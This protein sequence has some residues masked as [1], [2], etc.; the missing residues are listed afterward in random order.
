MC[1]WPPMPIATQAAGVRCICLIIIRLDRGVL[2]MKETNHRAPLSKV[3]LPGWGVLDLSPLSSLSF[4][5]SN[6]RPTATSTPSHTHRVLL[7]LKSCLHRAYSPTVNA[8]AQPPLLLATPLIH[9]Q[10]QNCRNTPH[11][12]ILKDFRLSPLFF[13][14]LT[15]SQAP[16]TNHQLAA[17]LT[18]L[19]P[20]T[21]P[22]LPH[23]PPLF[24]LCTLPATTF[25][26]FSS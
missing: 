16:P 11:P 13:F 7:F 21:P 26:F 25:S 6:A 3:C 18:H 20:L 2:K 14:F 4:V 17:Y 12:H 10:L 1:F 5:A 22:P 24:L 9:S 23:P 8:R 15:P 19:P